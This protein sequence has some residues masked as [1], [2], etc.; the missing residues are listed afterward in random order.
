VNAPPARPALFLDRDGVINLNHGY[1][2]TIE[3]F[4]FV[5]GIFETART[6]H[7]AGMA[8]VVV[9]NQAGIGRG[10]Y[11]EA[12]FAALSEW[13][14]GRFA[15][16]GAPIAA[17]YHCPHHPEAA[18][19][20]YRVRCD[21]RKPEPGMLLRARD[22]LGLDLGR[23]VLI[24]DHASDILAGRRA[25]VGTTIL[26]APDASSPAKDASPTLTLRSHAEIARWLSDHCG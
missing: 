7:D 22:A 19:G 26:F 11:D 8:L 14:R 18:L 13:M 1:V 24:G 4:D 17:V 20:P 2:H 5:D 16:A 9:T 12:T 10:Y 23:S 21:C 6:A 25:G 15:D 3:R